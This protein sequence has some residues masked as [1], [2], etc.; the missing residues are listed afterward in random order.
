MKSEA[1]DIHPTLLEW[2]DEELEYHDLMMES[3]QAGQ[4]EAFTEHNI[5]HLHLTRI[6][7]L[8]VEHPS[9]PAFNT[10]ASDGN[11]PGS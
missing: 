8:V 2:L 4:D 10:E 3:L 11:H 5:A 7:A 6:R 1:E 9:S